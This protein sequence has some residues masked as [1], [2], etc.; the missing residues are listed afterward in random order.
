MYL[1][2]IKKIYS[3]LL[4]GIPITKDTLNSAEIT[5]TQISSL[6]EDGVMFVDSKGIYRLTSINNL[7]LF[8]KNHL[9]HGRK[10][11]ALEC[12][13]LCYQLKPRH[14]YNCL[15]LF[16]N[17]VNK[18]NYGDAYKYLEA[19]ENVSTNEHLRK[20]YKIYLYLL[21]NL[22]EV[23][24]EYQEKFELINSDPT[25]LLHRKPTES[26]KQDNVI[27]RLIFKGKYK[28]ALEKLNDFL[29]EDEEYEVHRQIMKSLIKQIVSLREKYKM[30]LVEL[31]KKRRYRE[32]V[33]TLEE[34]SLTREL[35]SD[36][37]NVLQIVNTIISIFET[38]EIPTAIEN[39]ATKVTEAIQY[40]DF[41]KALELESEFIVSKCFPS[42]KSPMYILLVELNQLIKN[43]NR[44]ESHEGVK[45]LTFNQDLQQSIN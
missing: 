4:S 14:R 12:F 33:S 10:K 21:S 29:S 32:I 28:F 39:E 6:I 9:S 18:H 43:I 40:Y 42:D 22:T 16:F 23:P 37:S 44:I 3:L 41:E 35:R 5:D 2:F 7:F 17:S 19:L 27:M 34:T 8:G 30:S 24:E 38:G 20:D 36:E 13:N 45:K 25:I 26:Q 1:E 11:I 31:A 15:Q